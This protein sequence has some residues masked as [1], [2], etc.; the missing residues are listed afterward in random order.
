MG[1]LS[2]SVSI[3]RYRIDGQM[4]ENLDDA[5]KKGLEDF[6]FPAVEDETAEFASGWTSFSSPFSADF[7]TE[8][9]QIGR[10]YIFSLRIDKKTVPSQS[11]KKHVAI[12]SVKR[13]AGQEKTFLTKSEK[14]EIRD[15]V[16][17]MLMTRIP[18]KPDIYD[19]MWNPER[20]E[21]WFFSGLKVAGEELETL[22][23]KSF[24]LRLVR[25][26]PY[27]MAEICC[28]LSPAEKDNFLKLTPS[29]F[30]I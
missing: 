29:S 10:Y 22:F 14:K 8:K 3:T 2:G 20:N 15:N 23:S 28:D 16:I 30:R 13:L 21:V 24:N 6:C 25:L 5:V 9:F 11:V 7:D 27:S 1:I 4:P 19:V 12:E 17:S 18:S 26:F